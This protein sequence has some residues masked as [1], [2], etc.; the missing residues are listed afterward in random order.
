MD[1][2]IEE[3]A[4]NELDEG[5]KFLN[6]RKNQRPKPSRGL[7]NSTRLDS[8]H[9]ESSR[10]ESDFLKYVSSRVESS[11]TY[12]RVESSRVWLDR[13]DFFENFQ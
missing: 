6:R 12:L 13:L 5:L 3:E 9:N 2:R 4:K 7:G 8:T 11:E 1:Y 10:V